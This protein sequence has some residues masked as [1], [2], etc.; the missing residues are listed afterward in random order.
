[1]LQDFVEFEKPPLIVL[2]VDV[3]EAFFHCPKAVMRAKLWEPESQVDRAIMPTLSEI[4]FEQ[5][6]LGAPT[7]GEAEIRQTLVRQL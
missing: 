1:M 6:G 4:V 3:R 7:V 5:L 2:V